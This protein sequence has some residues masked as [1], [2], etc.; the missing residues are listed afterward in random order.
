MLVEIVNELKEE[1]E[2]ITP[3]ADADLE[4]GQE[5]AKPTKKVPSKT[6][7]QEDTSKQI[8]EIDVSYDKGDVQIKELDINDQAVKDRW[9]RYIGAMGFDAVAK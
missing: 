8:E 9:S 5:A 7:R 3:P 2:K 6:R 4:L 1:L